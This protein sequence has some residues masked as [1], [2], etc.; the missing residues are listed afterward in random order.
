[1]GQNPLAFVAQK[2]S[3]ALGPGLVDQQQALW[4]TERHGRQYAATYGSPVN[5][6]TPALAG[7]NFRG[8]NQVGATLSAALATTYVGLCLS[9][10]AGS[11][12]NLAVKR[13][14]Q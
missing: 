14:L 4:Q 13:A 8:S 1:M 3:K 2:F 12:V 11:G 9:N 6:S 10:P 7:T 5:G